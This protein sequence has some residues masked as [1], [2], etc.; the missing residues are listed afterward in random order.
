MRRRPTGRS[1]RAG[2]WPRRTTA[3]GPLFVHLHF[4]RLL[5]QLL[6]L[7]VLR[8]RE[9]HQSETAGGLGGNLELDLFIRLTR[10]RNLKVILAVGEVY[11]RNC[12]LLK[13][14]PAHGYDIANLSVSGL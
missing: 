5:D 6:V 8:C 14:L 4:N 3:S 7:G 1:N 10:D 12:V 11:L 2:I 13:V 9:D